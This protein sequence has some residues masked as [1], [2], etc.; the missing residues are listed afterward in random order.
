MKLVIL[1]RD[2]VINFDSDNYIK[3]VDEYVTIP[4]S[5]AAIARL[6]QHGYHVAVATNQSGIARGY[7]DEA[8]LHAMHQK[9]ADEL[10][11]FNST[12]DYIAY[13]PHAPDDGCNC[14]KPKTGLLQQI[15][16]H[17]Q[18]TLDQ[19]TIFVGDSPG[20]IQAAINFGVTPVLVKTGKGERTLQKKFPYKNIRIYTDLADFVDY[21]L[22]GK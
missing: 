5:V 9:L 18:M 4:G 6:K 17:F 7:Y 10:S 20:D 12:I 8:T 2:G 15:A 22:M 14:R 19:N 13:C 3:S 1:D 21:L 16:D 11:A